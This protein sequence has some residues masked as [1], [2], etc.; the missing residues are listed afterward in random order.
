MEKRRAERRVCVLKGSGELKNAEPVVYL[1][2]L[3][4]LLWLFARWVEMKAETG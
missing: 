1:N 2:C 4:D 3:G